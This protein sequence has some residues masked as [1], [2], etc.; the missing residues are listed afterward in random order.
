MSAGER[1]ISTQDK[2]DKVWNQLYATSI[3]LTQL[4]AELSEIDQSIEN[5]SELAKEVLELHLS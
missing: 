5:L 3:L 4:E 1:E 2:S